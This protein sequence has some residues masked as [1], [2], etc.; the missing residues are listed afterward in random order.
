MG[1]GNDIEYGKFRGSREIESES[2]SDIQLK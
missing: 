1:M 2:E